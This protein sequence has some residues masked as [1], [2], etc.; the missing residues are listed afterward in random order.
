MKEKKKLAC[1]LFSAVVVLSLA[2]P[3]LSPVV[4]ASPVTEIRDWYDLYAIRDDLAGHY[5]LVN[6]LN[7]TTV[8]YQ[9][10]AGPA[11]NETK[12]WEPIGVYDEQAGSFDPF[13]GT[14][15]GQGY[16]IRD[17]VINRVDEMAVG[18]FGVVV[19]WDEGGLI[20]NVGVM[21]AN[22]TGGVGV[23]G[24]VGLGGGTVRDCRSSGN[25]TGDS[26]VGGL[27]GFNIATVGEC[28]FEGMVRGYSILV[29]GLVGY[30]T[31]N[32]SNSYSGGTVT[33]GWGA[34]GVVGGNEGTV[35]NSHSGG[36]VIGE[37]YVGGLA[38]HNHQGTVGNCYS[39]GSVAGDLRVGGL[40]GYN[41][42]E[43]TVARSYASGSVT[44]DTLAGGLVGYNLGTVRDSYSS[45][46]VSGNSSVGGFVGG[47]EDIVRNCFWDKETSNMETSDGGTGKTTAEMISIAT[48]T[49]TKTHGLDAPWDITAVAHGETDDTYTWNIVDGERYPFLSGKQFIT[50]NLTI[51]SNAGGSVAVPGEGTYSCLAGEIV[52]LAGDPEAG[53]RFVNW[54]GD[55]D[56]VAD[57]NAARTSITMQGDYSVTANFE[58]EVS[59]ASILGIAA[60]V[61]VVGL[62]VFFLL[63]RRDIVAG[64]K[65]H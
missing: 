27:A 19:G 16:E 49:D 35:T 52:N 12:G 36:G 3:L 64:T 25:I 63:R 5:V 59:E 15:D 13:V 62:V 43:S 11:A 45:G 8:G 4:E 41:D 17:L 46:S 42:H 54:T 18:L 32:V 48:F 2:L 30:N 57:V 60:A 44:G 65:G 23:G 7:A 31:G 37:R 29:G 10:L 38:G 20:E 33:G 40:V 21:N 51:V 28:S 55:V 50:Y 14:L 6:D 26:R 9:E 58:R 56:T 34:G 47:N 22:V 53:Y 1:S 61:I 24:V 39:N